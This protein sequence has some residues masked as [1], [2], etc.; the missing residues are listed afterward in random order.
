M[1]PLVM[2]EL[3][4]NDLKI[5]KDHNWWFVPLPIADWY[6][7]TFIYSDYSAVQLLYL[8]DWFS[9]N[10]HATERLSWLE[11]DLL[12]TMI[13]S[14]TINLPVPAKV[15]SYINRIKAVRLS[16]LFSPRHNVNEWK[17]LFGLTDRVTDRAGRFV[18]KK[19]YKKRGGEIEDTCY[20]CA[21]FVLQ[22]YIFLVWLH[23]SCAHN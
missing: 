21:S 18:L 3:L 20:I 19:D 11:Q 15:Y 4:P 7:G 9:F 12:L 17:V 8:W 23:L 14:V 2:V 1:T 10:W 22:L 16:L 13:I 6:P 5:K